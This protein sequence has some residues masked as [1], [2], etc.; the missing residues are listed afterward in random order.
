MCLKNHYGCCDCRIHKIWL[1]S[2]ENCMLS[3][4]MV[5]STLWHCDNLEG[6]KTTME[7]MDGGEKTLLSTVRPCRIEVL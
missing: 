2:Q 3:N 7:I 5:S 4:E 6:P 1:E